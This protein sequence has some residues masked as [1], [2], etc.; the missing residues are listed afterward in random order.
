MYVCM[1]IYIYIYIYIYTHIGLRAE[2]STNNQRPK[3]TAEGQPAQEPA[4]TY[5]CTICGR[6]LACTVTRENTTDLGMRSII[7]QLTSNIHIYIL[8]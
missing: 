4:A 6:E 8:G 2:T 7:Q 1:Y 5:D 3:N